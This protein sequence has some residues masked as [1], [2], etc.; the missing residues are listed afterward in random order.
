MYIVYNLCPMC[1]KEYYL[2]LSKKEAGAYVTYRDGAGLIQ[3][4]FPELNP[5]EREFIKTG[6]CPHC[7]EILFGNGET[8]RIQE[9]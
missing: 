6:Y 7:Q 5:V 3:N 1:S 2:E 9:C 8:D 4:L